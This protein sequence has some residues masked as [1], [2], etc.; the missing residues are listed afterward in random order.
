MS[1]IE[2]RC[3]IWCAR[4]SAVFLGLTILF[5]IGQLTMHLEHLPEPFEAIPAYLVALFTVILGLSL[6]RVGE[7]LI[8]EAKARPGSDHSAF[9]AHIGKEVGVGFLVSGIALF[10]I[11]LTMHHSHQRHIQNLVDIRDDLTIIAKV[12]GN[13][14]EP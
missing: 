8:D 7:I 4:V 5:V 13:R 12:T 6:C 11:E 14:D 1:A 2:R 10:C 9:W 3:W